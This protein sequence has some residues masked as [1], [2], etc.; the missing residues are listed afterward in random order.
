MSDQITL[1]STQSYQRFRISKNTQRILIVLFLILGVA[2]GVVSAEYT[3]ILGIGIAVAVIVG[4]TGLL[5]PQLVT[6]V[7]AFLIYA[8]LPVVATQYGI[9]PVIAG[10]AVLLLGLPLLYYLLVQKEDII[11][12]HGFVLMIIYLSITMISALFSADMLDSY[13]RISTYVLEGMILYF[14]FINTIR[15]PKVL[16]AVLWAMIAAGILMGTISLFQ[17][18]TKTYDNDYWGMAQSKDSELSVS[19]ADFFGDKDYTRRLAGPVGSKNRYAQ[20][21]LVL[22]PLAFVRILIP[23]ENRLLRLVALY[24]VIPIIAG[25]LLTFSRGAGIAI[26][27]VWFFFL[28]FRLIP[29][30]RSILLGIGVAIIITIAMP[31]FAF[32]FVSVL[33]V[34]ALFGDNIQEEAD[35]AIRG[36]ATVNL[37]GIYIWASSPWLGV[38]PGQS[39]N[40]VREVGNEV[41]FRWL[42]TNRRLHNM[43]VEE[44][45]DTGVI[46]VSSFLLIILVTLKLLNDQR[47]AWRGRNDEYY[48]TIIGVMVA[49][50]A[51]MVSAVFLHLSYI[52]FFW[53]LMAVAGA[54]AFVYKNELKN[55][56]KSTR[57]SI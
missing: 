51:Y 47:L 41:G 35:G 3:P 8:N 29:I 53:M 33:D 39:V 27:A 30:W 45:A 49:I 16:R 40:Y 31:S 1:S 23:N 46:G 11:I 56:Q 55:L 2:I 10:S 25:T 50:L 12:N 38:G 36:R 48:Y 6:S 21:M 18:V 52:R 32:R 24:A 42:T 34:F 20:V 5:R 37:A 57:E 4:M 54:T 26:V 22:L 9:P 13:E 19:D 43:Y 7:T 44:L 28:I 15:T 17:E 14:L